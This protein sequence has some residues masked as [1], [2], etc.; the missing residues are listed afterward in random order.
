MTKSRKQINK[1]HQIKKKKF[2]SQRKT[3]AD[4]PRQSKTA[5]AIRK[6]RSRV[7]LADP[8]LA[9][10][11]RDGFQV[12]REWWNSSKNKNVCKYLRNVC[13]ENKESK[14]YTLRGDANKLSFPIHIFHNVVKE[15]AI[16]VTSSLGL[17]GKITEQNIA[18]IVTHQGAK[19][20]SDHV[21]TEDTRAF[22]VLHMMTD[23]TIWVG[24][25]QYGLK[26]LDVLVM[27]GGIC[28]AGAQHTKYRPTMMLHVPVGYDKEITYVCR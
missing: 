10:L 12:F 25:K 17:Q 4:V 16:E 3:R 26:D 5:S 21:D 1:D 6:R 8:Y 27:K 2:T 13:A 23:R 11:A 22:S 24:S 19:K 15:T 14:E 20:Q 9:T 7:E 18:C 28:L